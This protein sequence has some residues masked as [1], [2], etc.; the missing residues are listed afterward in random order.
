MVL[1]HEIK[2]SKLFGKDLDHYEGSGV[3][4]RDGSLYMVFDD[5]PRLGI[6]D[7]GLTTGHLGPG[8]TAD[9]QFESITANA[10]G[11]YVVVEADAAGTSQVIPFDTNGNASAPQPTD[12]S[13]VAN[14][15]KGI[16]GAA[17]ITSGGTEYLLALCEGNFCADDT[18]SYGNGR[19]KVLALANGRWT[20]QTTLSIPSAA[21]FADYADL[22][23]R[24]RG[25]S[26]FDIAVLSQASAALWL[27]T[28]T[29]SPFAIQG[30]G[31]IFDF[32]KNADGTEAYCELEGITFLDASTFAMV[33]DKTNDKT[34]CNDKD[35]SA[36]I[37][38]LPQ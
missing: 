29:T 7:V 18:T 33:S 37:F 2:L 27:G 25:D 6:A 23:I 15:N 22:A 9:S 5:S 10:S 36:H 34:Y 1:D 31:Q 3:A 19:I 21:A 20:T 38:H 13:F 16:E 8:G 28:L 4:L 26:S 11:F 24:A 14:P 30:P 35:T 12:A 32:P 17:W